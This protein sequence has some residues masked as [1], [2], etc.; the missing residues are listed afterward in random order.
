MIR[1]IV[2]DVV[3]KVAPWEGLRRRNHDVR[4][5]V[6]GL[7]CLFCFVLFVLFACFVCFVCFVCFLAFLLAGWLA[8]W[9]VCFVFWLAC[10]SACSLAALAAFASARTHGLVSLRLG[11]LFLGFGFFPVLFRILL[12]QEGF[13]ESQLCVGHVLSLEASEFLDALA[14]FLLPGLF[15]ELVPLHRD[16]RRLEGRLLDFRHGLGHGFRL[17][18]AGVPDDLALPGPLL[19]FAPVF[20]LALGLALLSEGLLE[21]GLLLLL[22]EGVGLD[23]LPFLLF[24]GGPEFQKLLAVALVLVLEEEFL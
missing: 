23:F 9:L 8:G 22:G 10:F 19:L 3:R 13:L 15:V 5:S 1:R 18:V 11:S 21:G 16:G 6:V 12:Q 7:F 14:L 20:L 24:Q 4:A 2:A 17:V